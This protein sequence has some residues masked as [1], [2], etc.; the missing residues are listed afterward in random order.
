MPTQLCERAHAR[1]L[2]AID[3]L[4]VHSPLS[5]L[6]LVPSPNVLVCVIVYGRRRRW[7]DSF[8]RPALEDGAAAVPNTSSHARIVPKADVISVWTVPKLLRNYAH[9][10]LRNVPANALSIIVYELAKMTL[11]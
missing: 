9:G 4:R 1:S 6:R 10:V 11:E 2:G 5:A 3:P 8:A 7:Y